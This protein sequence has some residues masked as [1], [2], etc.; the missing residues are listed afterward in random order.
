MSYLV[1]AR[2]WRPQVF[3]KIVGQGHISLTLKNAIKSSRIS[4]AY[5]FTGP[6]GIGKTT[7]ARILA[8]ALN[9]AQGV[10]PEP[11]NQCTRCKEITEGRSLDVLEID[12]A[13]NRGI[14]EVRNLRE[15]IKYAPVG[16]RYKI[17]IID[18]VHMLTKEA[19]NAL[20]KT[21]EEPPGHTVFIFATTEPH[22]VPA[23]ILSR[24]QRFDFHRISIDDMIENL[25]QIAAQE[26]I[27][28]DDECLRIMAR[29]ADGSLR[30]AQSL[31]D[32]MVS[33][34][35]N[36]VSLEDVVNTLGIIPQDLFF[37]VSDRI[38]A[39]DMGGCLSLIDGVVRQ[40]YDPQE[41]LIGLGEHF[42]NLLLTRAL[43]NA[44]LVEATPENKDRYLKEGS[45]YQENDLLRLIKIVA[46]AEV[47][48]R[49][50]PHW[51]LAFELAFLKMIKLEESVQIEGVIERLV[52]LKTGEDQPCSMGVKEDLSPKKKIREKASSPEGLL[53]RGEE[54]AVAVVVPSIG[55]NDQEKL[56]K[57]KDSW[58]KVVAE[59][60]ERK[61]SLGVFL[62]LGEPTALKEGKL[63]VTLSQG[64]GFQ[65]GR[66]RK[67]RDLI[68]GA[69]EKVLGERWSVEFVVGEMVK[70]PAAK[71]RMGD[72]K[73]KWLEGLKQKEPIIGDIM[74]IFKGEL[75]E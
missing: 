52:G 31:L 74:E 37:Q 59:V 24:C 65:I 12:G 19:F 60:G 32:Q 36:K 58:N 61:K 28:V 47:G 6:R 43:G 13:S 3:E 35:G 48:L 18:E 20:L 46:D 66:L 26:Q 73:K 40:G 21:L 51:R 39:R 72:D 34:G 56:E 64:N 44:E 63:T 55:A 42:R 10:T 5:I 49:R 41:F 71:S 69:V 4:H 1:M 16:G 14:D 62:V 50:N 22:R 54:Q 11:C 15:N 9:C 27:E 53:K 70:S 2:K 8:K 33:F 45:S 30:D 7:T 23:T 57:V 25:R 68:A 75:V 67:E 38:R 29:K 17:Y